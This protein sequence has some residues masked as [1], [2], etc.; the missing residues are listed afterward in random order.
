MVSLGLGNMMLTQTCPLV[1]LPLRTSPPVVLLYEPPAR[2]PT[3]WTYP[4]VVQHMWSTS[5][6][7][8]CMQHLSSVSTEHTNLP[9]SYP[10]ARVTEYEPPCSYHGITSPDPSI[11]SYI[12][13]THAA[14][15]VAETPGVAEV[16][17]G[18][19]CRDCLAVQSPSPGARLTRKVLVSLLSPGGS[20]LAARRRSLAD[21]LLWC[22]SPSGP[23]SATRRTHDGV[24]PLVH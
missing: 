23:H 7:P 21:P 24:S 22:L 1:V 18:E 20:P 15:I 3:L 13:A 9:R 4:P 19:I 8:P 17:L 11:A 10:Y 14:K 16:P 12:K 5:H 6:V 2:S